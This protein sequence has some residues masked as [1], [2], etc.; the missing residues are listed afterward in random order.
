MHLNPNTFGDIGHSSLVFD[1]NTCIFNQPN[2]I[3]CE[4]QKSKSYTCKTRAVKVFT[5][6]WALYLNF[7][8]C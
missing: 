7:G 8:T 1:M 3:K 2:F 6:F 5:Q 4:S